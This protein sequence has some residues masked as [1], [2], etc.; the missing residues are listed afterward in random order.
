MPE[1]SPSQTVGPFFDFSLLLGG[2][3]I[4]VNDQTKGEKIRIVGAVFD[5]DRQPIP[6]AMLE[7]WQADSHGF[8]NHPLDPNQQQADKNFK[9]FGRSGTAQAGRYEFVTVKPGRVSGEDGQLQVPHINVRL[10]ARGML[11]HLYT[12]LYFSDESANAFDALLN[13]VDESRRQTLI[14][15]AEPEHTYRFN[16]Y[17]QGAN[18]TVFFEP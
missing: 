3:N 4:L 5:G 12:R 9:G 8:F 1:Q 6:D 10:F 13:T 18:E 16:I 2:E 14:A 17:M 7:I 11:I 15:Q